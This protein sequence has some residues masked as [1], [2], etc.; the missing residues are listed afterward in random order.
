MPPSHAVVLSS[1]SMRR[2]FCAVALLALAG[3]LPRA[4]RVGMAGDYV[5][6]IS[7]ITARDEALYGHTAIAMARGGDWVSLRL[8][9]RAALWKA[10]LLVWTAALSARLFGITRFALRLPVVISAALAIALIFLWG[11]EMSGILSGAIAALLMLGNHLFHT[12]AT[13]CMSDA[14]LLAFTSAAV[15]AIYADPWLES[16]AA[17]WGFATATAAAILT[18]GIAGM[19]PIAVLG[20]FCLVVRPNERPALPRAALAA[21][22]AA[23]LTA[24]WFLA[25]QIPG[26]GAAPL[27]SS[28]ETPLPFYL[29]R[30]AATDPILFAGV[31]VAV[32]AFAR[33]L[34]SRK[35]GPA[36]LACWLV[37]ATIATFA[38]RD[39]SASNLLALVPAL[40]LMAACYGPFSER[41]HAP[42]ML[43]MVC[44]GLVVKAALPGVPWGLN[45]RAGTLNPVAPALSDYCESRRSAALIVVDTADDLYASLLPIPLRYAAV[46]SPRELDALLAANP[47]SDFLVPDRDPFTNGTPDHQYVPAAPGFGFLIATHPKSNP[48]PPHPWTCRM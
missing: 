38:W 15:Y 34:R 30:I 16:R 42:W 2:A 45:F 24:P 22:M 9:D 41:R 36:L 44:V 37:L 31:I 1:S 28:N 3:L 27:Q 33:V 7:R 32:P 48:P 40:A 23:A 43:G 25:T 46:G 6:T 21:G 4:V 14:L 17:L 10:P 47:D 20:L 26:F 39:R 13:L 18:K 5:D 8:M 35:A 11:S 12:L 19:L 29:L